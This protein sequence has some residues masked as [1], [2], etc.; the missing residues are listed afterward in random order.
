M[1]VTIGN[2]EINPQ[3]LYGG[4]WKEGYALD[5]HSVGSIPLGYNAFGYMQF[6]TTYTVIGEMLNQLKYHNDESQVEKIADVVAEFLR[7]TLLQRRPMHRIV[8]VPPSKKRDRQPVFL[9]AHAIGSQLG[10][11]VMENAVQR[12]KTTSAAKNTDDIDQRRR[13]QE[14]AFAIGDI[15]DIA[16]AVVLLFDDLYQSGATAGS[17]ARLLKE[18][19]DAAE[20]YFLAITRTRKSP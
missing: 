15:R 11:P 6:D 16:G 17:V 8:P 2:I 5:I 12:V 19:G 1:P 3:R 20:I 4:S 10:I 7:R 14:S 13:D 18:Q 9:L